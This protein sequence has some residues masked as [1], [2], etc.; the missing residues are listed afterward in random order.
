MFIGSPPDCLQPVG[1][2]T[3][4]SRRAACCG[5]ARSAGSARCRATT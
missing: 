2:A 4:V 5:R 3:P 1:L